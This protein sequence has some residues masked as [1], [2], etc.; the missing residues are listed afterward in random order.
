MR[1]EMGT[2]SSVAFTCIEFGWAISPAGHLVPVRK[3][4]SFI[5][6]GNGGK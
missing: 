2:T 3:V 1:N 6:P 4:F 5:D